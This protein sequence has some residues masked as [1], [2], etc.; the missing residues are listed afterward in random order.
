M[1]TPSAN[2][3]PPEQVSVVIPVYNQARYLASAIESVLAQAAP[4]SEILVVDDG[5]TDDAESVVRRYPGVRYL[6]QENRGCA[7]ARNRGQQETRG[8]I[9]V[10]LDADDR[11]LPGAFE[12]GLAALRAR[13]D[14]AL[15]FG[16]AARVGPDGSSLELSQP[17]YEATTDDY[18]VFLAGCP[19]W[20]PA[21]VMCRRFVF[22]EGVAFDPSLVRSSDY[23]FYL[24]VARRWPVFGHNEIVSEYRQ[25]EAARSADSVRVLQGALNILRS[26]R[27]FVESV[28]ERRAARRQGFAN[29]RHTY[30]LSAVA[31]TWRRLKTGPDR[32]RA[33]QD[34]AMLVGLFPSALYQFVTR[35][36][37]RSVRR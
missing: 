19:I 35:R 29:Y 14:C 34:A 23:L 9:L 13:P 15:V 36:L 28:P 31:Q 26:Q 27:R 11:L 8:N 18:A 16:R 21:S 2:P 7:A 33:V 22:E 17:L 12:K 25:H 6:H 32:K 10:F 3:D 37:I 24:D 20:H 5:S 30:Y 1:P 4:A